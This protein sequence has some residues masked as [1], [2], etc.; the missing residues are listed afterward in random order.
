[1]LQLNA[2][3]GISGGA[4]YGNYIYLAGGANSLSGGNVSATG[5]TCTADPG[6]CGGQTDIIQYAMINSSGNITLND[7]S[8]TTGGWHIASTRLYEVRRR[9]TAFAANGYF[10]VVAGH[11]GAAGVTLQD[12][13]RG[14]IDINTGDVTMDATPLVT[15]IT[16]RWDLR[17]AQANGIIYV[18]GGCTAGPPPADCGA[19]PG[20]EGSNSSSDGMN[21]I[22]EYLQI[23]NN[24]TGSPVSY[25][26]QSPVTAPADRFGASATINDGYIYLA[27][28]CTSATDC[29]T[30]TNNV[31]YAPINPDGTI[32]TANWVTSG[33]IPA[34]RAFGCLVT[35]GG[36]LYYLGGQN[37]TA[38]ASSAYN[39][40]YYSDIGGSGAPGT[41]NTASNALSTARSSASCATYNNR[42]YVSGGTTAAPAYQNTVLISPSLP[43]GGNI[44]SAW[45]SSANT[46]TGTRSGHSTIAYGNN[47]YVIGGFDG[48][49]YLM[50]V[51]YALINSNGTIG[52]WKYGTPL[53]Q[54]IRQ[55]DA[56]AAN[57]FL[58]IFGGRSAATTCTSNTYVAPINANPIISKVV[59]ENPSAIGTW[60]QTSVAYSGNRYGVAAA[61]DSGRAYLIGGMCNGTLTNTN[62]VVY[63]TLQAQPQISRYSTMVDADGDVYPSK[64]LFNGI[65]SGIGARWLLSYSSSKSSINTWGQSTKHGVITLGTPGPYV[66][67]DGAGANSL[68]ARYYY[69][70]LIIDASQSFGFPEDSSRGPTIDD[71]T[72]QLSADPSKRLRNGKTFIGGEQQPLDTPF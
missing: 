64:F 1:M 63:G 54:A 5:S 50:D 53:P 14:K 58:Y 34:T 71:M 48:T 17:A 46:F 52:T 26:A 9:T 41:W 35:I 15:G 29:T 13:L 65:D 70:S 2:A 38:G 67:K 42:I 7:G 51:Q 37:A 31:S 32:T 11:D 4:V 57:G 36:T 23:Y 39:T 22:V 12:V 66:A 20:T 40:V 10:Y 30:Y 62:R 33:S 19:T 18:L 72:L 24:G 6:A 8:T 28:G 61:Y 3:T 49:N 44:A 21:G 45:S 68:S 56:F 16:E 25:T 47:L 27:G 59:Q 43:T 69:L 55:A 60:S